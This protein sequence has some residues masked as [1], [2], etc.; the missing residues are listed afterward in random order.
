[1]G[2]S[3]EKL[4]EIFMVKGAPYKPY[5]FFVEKGGRRECLELASPPTPELEEVVEEI[6][7]NFVTKGEGLSEDL[8]E[9]EEYVRKKK[10]L[11]NSNLLLSHIK[12]FIKRNLLGLG[13][14][15]S[16][17]CHPS[18]E[19]ISITPSGV[20]YVYHPDYGTMRTNIV[21]DKDRL[22]QKI[23]WKTGKTPS[24]TAPL[25]RST[26]PA[27][28]RVNI[29]LGRV[30]KTGSSIHFRRR[31]RLMS[32]VDLLKNGTLSPAIASLLWVLMSARKTMLII[33]QPSSGK[34][35]MLN[36]LLFL[37]PHETHIV[38]I[39]SP[40]ELRLFHEQ[41]E[42]LI[43]SDQL[44][45]RT[46]RP[47]TYDDILTFVLQSRPGYVVIGEIHQGEMDLF[48]QL[49]SV[50]FLCSATLH[51]ETPD[52]MVE[53]LTSNP[54]GGASHLL[55]NID[56]VVKMGARPRE[57]IVRKIEGIFYR[58]GRQ[59][60]PVWEWSWTESDWVE[61]ET[62]FPALHE[63]LE[64]LEMDETEL[65]RRERFLSSCPGGSDPRE[66]FDLIQSYFRGTGLRAG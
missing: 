27:G 61:A 35:T 17:M 56:V 29:A 60:R 8:R 3:E 38:T 46:A 41:W 52:N 33:G 40:A 43:P 66:D 34:T 59:W 5:V 21:A 58:R 36:A 18:L 23:A 31:S 6:W 62:E 14:I 51:A 15:H 44:Q 19:D 55:K 2:L 10:S 64:Y 63:A 45:S 16:L 53:R 1:M 54:M 48:T 4:R 32:I 26:L 30:S 39:E 20:V 37:L 24:F 7:A 50:P 25:V 65:E 57:R 47:I 9:V 22:I 28:V 13:E 49:L 42:Q 11:R 12:H